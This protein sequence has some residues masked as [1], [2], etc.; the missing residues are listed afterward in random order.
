M[1]ESLLSIIVAL[2]AKSQYDALKIVE[3]LDPTLCRVKVGKELFTH[4]GPSVVKKLQEEN[5]EVF[6]DLKFHDI[7]N[8]TA[9]AVCAAADLGVWMVNVHASGGR[10]MMET[11]V[12]RLKAGNYQTQLIAV[13]VL[14]SM[15]REDLK[16][17]GLDIEPVEQVKRLAKLTKESGLDGVVCSAQEAKILREL[18][19]QVFSLV[20]P[21]IR[22][23]G[24]NAD[25]QKRIV[26]PKQAML[27]GSTHL[28]IG[29]PITNAENPTEML[30]SILASIA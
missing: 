28:V 15:G 1:E 2:D 19:G 5:F 6:L 21:G 26:T 16:D 20:T 3:Q 9:Q 27:D 14:T 8:T 11:C 17:I 24:S 12:E 13:T 30:K 22:P 4:E 23:E 10:K 29:R 18:I 7:P 25:D